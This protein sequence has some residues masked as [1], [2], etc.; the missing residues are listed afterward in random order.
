MYLPDFFK[1]IGQPVLAQQWIGKTEEKLNEMLR[2][3]P[4]S[5][6]RL[7]LSS[8]LASFYEHYEMYRSGHQ[9]VSELAEKFPKSAQAADALLKVGMI[10]QFKK[11]DNPKALDVYRE[12]VKQY[13]T[14]VVRRKV[15]ARN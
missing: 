1:K 11:K 8:Y 15:E 2:R 4:T 13:P 3:V 5:G 6:R 9:P 12:F 10:Y 7:W 14:S